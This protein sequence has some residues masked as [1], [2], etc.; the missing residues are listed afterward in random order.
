MSATVVI[1]ILIPQRC[2]SETH[3]SAVSGPHVSAL[4]H[5]VDSTG[6]MA[7]DLATRQNRPTFVNL[8]REECASILFKRDDELGFFAVIDLLRGSAKSTDKF[9]L[10]NVGADE[11]LWYMLAPYLRGPF[12]H[13]IGPVW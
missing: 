7:Q 6:G 12:F 3:V 11:Q 4:L 13:T 9:A 2:N 1:P 10:D 5:V 8:T